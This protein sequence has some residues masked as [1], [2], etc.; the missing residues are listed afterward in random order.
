M[1]SFQTWYRWIRSTAA[2]LWGSGLTLGN[3]LGAVGSLIGFPGAVVAIYVFHAELVDLVTQPDVTAELRE[4]T[5]RCDYRFKPGELYTRYASG[6]SGAFGQICREAPLGVSFSYEIR[7][8]DKIERLLRSLRVIVDIPTLGPQDLA[9]AYDVE[10]VVRNGHDEAVQRPWF[11]K[12]LAPNVATTY[13]ALTL[14]EPADGMA[15]DIP[16]GTLIDRIAENEAAFTDTQL[17]FQLF[18]QF[19]ESE[20][21]LA[22]CTWRFEAERVRQFLDSRPDHQFQLTGYC[23]HSVRP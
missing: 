11:V 18:G 20:I 13:E 6:E 16:F 21:E 3:T 9:F 2:A 4:V 17:R 10:H 5:L 12:R 1:R 19:E 7:N 23:D 15:N 22:A 8:E 14:V